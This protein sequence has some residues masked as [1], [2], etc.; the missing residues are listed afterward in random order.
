MELYNLIKKA[1]NFDEAAMVALT[2]K[3]K[4]ILSKYAH[5][6][7]VEDAY[8]DLLADFIELIYR[9]PLDKMKI[10]TDGAII[11]YIAKSVY[12]AYI[13]LSRMSAKKKEMA[14]SELSE[15][16][17]HSALRTLSYC[18]SYFDDMLYKPKDLTDSEFRILSLLFVDGLSGQEVANKL[19]ISRQAVNQKKIR[20]LNKFKQIYRNQKTN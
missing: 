12:H 5:K 16:E 20:A 1:Q 14:F 9:F 7:I 18:D 19:N 10:L 13:K 11:N 6:L 8:S 3:F 4:P 15:K 17:F 2:E